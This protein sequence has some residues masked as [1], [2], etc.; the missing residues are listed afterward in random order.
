MLP[1]VE[2]DGPTVRTEE[3]GNM[4]IVGRIAIDCRIHNGNNG[5]NG[6]T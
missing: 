3:T 5:I 1:K 6:E 2:C 4:L